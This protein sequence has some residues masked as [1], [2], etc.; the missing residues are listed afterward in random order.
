MYIHTISPS[1]TVYG[2]ARRYGVSPT[3]IIENNRLSDPD[4]LTIGQKLLILTP[5]K[6]YT[7]RGGDTLEKISKRFGISENS[8]LRNNPSLFGTD[9][10]YPEQILAL[11]YDTPTHGVAVLNGYYYNGCPRERLIFTLPYLN[12][13]TVSGAVATQNG[14][15]ELFDTGEVAREVREGGRIPMYRIYDRRRMEDIKANE[16]EYIESLTATAKN[17][18]FSGI[19]LATHKAQGSPDFEDFLFRL[20]KRLIEEGLSLFL[21]VDANSPIHYTDIPD[22]QLLFYEKCGLESIPDFRDG[23]D[24]V[25]TDF[26]ERGD[27][28]RAFIDISPF[29][30]S[31][32]AQIPKNEAEAEARRLQKEIKHDE[33][34]KICYFETLSRGKE[35]GTRRTVYESMENIKAK[36]D[37]AGELG[38]MGI[39]FDIMRV[40]T[41]ELMMMNS[42]FL[43][44]GDVLPLI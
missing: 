15:K 4:R 32:G 41:S 20:K 2:I 38:Y 42:L 1:D 22:A 33:K 27:S 44:G 12:Y 36:L 43:C 28:S 39:S 23:E 37:L 24:A 13:V 25:F 18:G 5:T 7:V 16:H 40:P 14:I 11:K 35:S 3:K 26:A 10:T 34:K 21:E 19:T 17:R 31:E 8:L 9:K 30:Y 6:T 29:A